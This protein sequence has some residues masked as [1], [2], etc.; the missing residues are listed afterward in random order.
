MLLK[1][2]TRKTSHEATRVLETCTRELLTQALKGELSFSSVVKRICLRICGF[3]KENTSPCNFE[4]KNN[5]RQGCMHE[6]QYFD[7]VL[8]SFWKAITPR[9]RGV[10]GEVMTHELKLAR[11]LLFQVNA[12]GSFVNYNYLRGWKEKTY[13][14]RNR[15]PCTQIKMF[16]YVSTLSRFPYNVSNHKPLKITNVRMTKLHAWFSTCVQKFS[17]SDWITEQET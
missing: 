17:T 15:N 9:L 3:L 8:N 6:L 10:P 13:V 5:T 4:G 11:V 1:V 14:L 7:P 2:S 16:P 12:L